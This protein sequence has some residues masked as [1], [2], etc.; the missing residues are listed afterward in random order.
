MKFQTYL[1]HKDTGE[2]R[3]YASAGHRE[4]AHRKIKLSS[5]RWKNPDRKQ[6]RLSKSP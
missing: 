4:A 1:E 6:I 2:R 5:D 3:Y